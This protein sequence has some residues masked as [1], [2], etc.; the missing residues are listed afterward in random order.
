MFML[1]P[2]IY[3]LLK[4]NQSTIFSIVFVVKNTIEQDQ[5]FIRILL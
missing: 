4:M 5:F 3:L 2:T 1:T